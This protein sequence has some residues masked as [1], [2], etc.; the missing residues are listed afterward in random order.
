MYVYLLLLLL[1]RSYLQFIQHKIT[2]RVCD[3]G[4]IDGW[5]L[6]KWEINRLCGIFNGRR[7]IGIICI[8]QLFN[9]KKLLFWLDIRCLNY[10]L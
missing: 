9:F 7:V 2:I 3:K 4:S 1:L 8:I 5:L 10:G 6:I